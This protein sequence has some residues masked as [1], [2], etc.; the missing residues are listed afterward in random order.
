MDY[1]E[2][3]KRT[4]EWLE[5]LKA[6]DEVVVSHGYHSVGRLEKVERVTA[7]QIVISDSL[8]FRRD[9]GR[10][11]GGSESYTRTAI[12]EATPEARAEIRREALRNRMSLVKWEK[13][14]LETLEKVA[15][16]LASDT[17]EA[18]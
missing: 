14:S 13:V 18:K 9:G 1:A 7:T 12:E 2:R 5:G 10:K 17:A 15:A 11:V 8:R 4:K 3:A 16:A 6:G